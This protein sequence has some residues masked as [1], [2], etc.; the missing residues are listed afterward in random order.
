MRECACACASAG[1]AH[2]HRA[3]EVGGEERWELSSTQAHNNQPRQLC[4]AARGAVRGSLLPQR[5]QREAKAGHQ[6][7][8]VSAR[9]VIQVERR[10][11]SRRRSRCFCRG[12]AAAAW[13]GTGGCGRPKAHLALQRRVRVRKR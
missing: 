12:C 7:R 5:R 10:E 8:V 6:S 13:P 11:A 1:R 9:E 3:L 2:V 4:P